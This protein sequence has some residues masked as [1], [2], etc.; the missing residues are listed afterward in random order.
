MSQEKQNRQLYQSTFQKIHAPKDL[1]RKVK[2]MDKQTKIKTFTLRKIGVVAAAFVLVLV[3]SNVITYAASGSTWIG[4]A[5][6]TMN[7]QQQE[8]D[9]TIQKSQE[10]D[11]EEGSVVNI[12]IGYNAIKGELSDENDIGENKKEMPDFTTSVEKEGDQVFLIVNGK[13][14]N[15][16]EDLT[17]EK[18]EGTFEWEEETYRYIVMGTLEENTIAITR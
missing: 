12:S 14:I 6:L 1:L 7:G 3:S 2:S 5:M 17:D 15:I 9:V 13:K 18:C 4:K 8:V 16:T 11:Q 10:G